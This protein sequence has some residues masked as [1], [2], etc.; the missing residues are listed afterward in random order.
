MYNYVLGRTEKIRSLRC[1]RFD[2]PSI[3][4]SPPFVWNAR[5]CFHQYPLH[6]YIISHMMASH[7][8]P[9]QRNPKGPCFAYR[10]GCETFLS[11]CPAS[12]AN[13]SNASI[14]FINIHYIPPESS[15]DGEFLRAFPSI[16]TPQTLPSP[17][18]LHVSPV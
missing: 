7:R 11:I 10:S 14:R 18:E 12:Q 9:F 2:F 15:C 1:L 16:G 6:C 5:I 13:L 4:A 8:A 3:I 17:T